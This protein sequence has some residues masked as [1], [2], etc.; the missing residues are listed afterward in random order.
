[1]S[2]INFDDLEPIIGKSSTDFSSWFVD[3]SLAYFSGNP[4]KS[5]M[6]FVPVEHLVTPGRDRTEAE[7]LADIFRALGSFNEVK[8]Q[9]NF[10]SGLA[11]ALA[12]FVQEWKASG[13]E[14][15]I[16]LTSVE[17][18]L[19]TGKIIGCAKIVESMEAVF[20]QT[21]EL[22]GKDE[23]RWDVFYETLSAVAA[24]E[25][26][27]LIAN[28][29]SAEG[30]RGY[31][32]PMAF[33]T[34]CRADKTRFPTWLEKLRPSLTQLHQDAMQ[35]NYAYLTAQKFSKWVE[36]ETAAKQLCLMRLSPDA[37]LEGTDNWLLEALVAEPAS[38]WGLTEDL[39]LGWRN[40]QIRLPI[41]V[42]TIADCDESVEYDFTASLTA[43]W[44]KSVES[45]P[46]QVDSLISK[47]RMQN[48]G[49]QAE[50]IRR[51]NQRSDAVEAR[52]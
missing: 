16:V 12:R 33:L 4:Q 47:Y 40:D 26:A 27:D 29:V 23:N 32:A 44:L 46:T 11:H 18:L 42:L 43:A 24:K 30:F 9:S 37:S 8:A 2:G 31:M 20:S 51:A 48:K 34:L 13:W 17:L 25:D 21:A 35:R 38:P 5:I 3:E 36:V 52:L 39:K 14:R 19:R 7:C 10:K 22:F 15:P 28:M 45:R 1:M 6:A 50:N 41:Q 49:R